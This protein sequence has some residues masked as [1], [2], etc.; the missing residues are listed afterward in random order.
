MQTVERTVIRWLLSPDTGASS[1]AICAHMIG[2]KPE[3]NDYS[4]PSDPSDLG[5]CLRL[6]DL[7]PE[8]KPRIHE[9]AVYG[10]AW[11][12]LIKQWGVI[13]DLYYNES[14]VPLEQRKLSPETNRAMKL[15]IADGYRNDPRFICHFDEEG[16]LSYFSCKETEDET[17]AEA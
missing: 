6:L 7:V 5:R 2:E 17:E 8:W 16:M 11:A 15:A 3:D 10:P 4:A 12:G 13:V 14:G 9:M 1:T